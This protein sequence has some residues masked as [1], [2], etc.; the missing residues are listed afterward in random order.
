MNYLVF[1]GAMLIVLFLYLMTKKSKLL[2]YGTCT[3][4]VGELLMT[5]R[6]NNP[7]II[8]FLSLLS[9]PL[10]MEAGA[11]PSR[12]QPRPIQG[13]F[14]FVIISAVLGA[15]G[16]IKSHDFL[17]GH[18]EAIGALAF[19]EYETKYLIISVLLILASLILGLKQYRE[20]KR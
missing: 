18:S 7:E 11:A 4:L 16:L 12:I 9:L 17:Y 20:K 8:F 2:T 10:L 6:L 14:F 1:T 13:L 15:F 3:V 19:T 5:L